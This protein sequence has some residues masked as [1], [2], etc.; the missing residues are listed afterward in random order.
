MPDLLLAT[1][2]LRAG[3]AASA[4]ESAL[5]Q[6]LNRQDEVLG[7]WVPGS[8]PLED[9]LAAYS[10]ASLCCMAAQ[11]AQ[12]TGHALV[13]FDQVQGAVAVW[14]VGCQ[15]PLIVLVVDCSLFQS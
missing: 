5:A 13:S 14:L 2:P 8:D 7:P 11:S 4:A 12:Q 3:V 10:G 1:V 15:N 9:A 6:V